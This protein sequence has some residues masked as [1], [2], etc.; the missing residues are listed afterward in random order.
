MSKLGPD[1][2]QDVELQRTNIF[3]SPF[4]EPNNLEP[5]RKAPQSEPMLDRI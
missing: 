4:V 1:I 3:Y 5:S 2:S